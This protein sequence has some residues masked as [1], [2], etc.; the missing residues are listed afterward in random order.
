MMI[1]MLLWVEQLFKN[2]INFFAFLFIINFCIKDHDSE[3][4]SIYKGITGIKTMKNYKKYL[5]I[6]YKIDKICIINL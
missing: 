6:M 2:N 5:H 4:A 1:I 3:K